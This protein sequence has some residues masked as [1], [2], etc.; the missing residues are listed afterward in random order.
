MPSQRMLLTPLR[1]SL[2][3]A[4]QLPVSMDSLPRLPFPPSP[5]TAWAVEDTSIQ[6]AWGALPTGT[7]TAAAVGGGATVTNVIDHPGGPGAVDIDGL[8]PN[9]Q[10]QLT[11]EVAGTR[12]TCSARTLTPPPGAELFRFATISDMHLGSD[13]FGASKRM[14]DRSNHPE[15]FALRSASH[16]IN[17]ATAWGAKHL[18]IKGDAAH[19]ARVEDFALL[20]E[21]V[22]RHVDVPMSLLPGNHDNDLRA[23][24]LPATVGKRALRYERGVSHLDVP[25]LR[26]V[27]GDTTI[28]GVGSGTLNAIGDALLTAAAESPS[29]TAFLA[30]HQQLQVNDPNRYWPPGIPSDQSDPFLEQLNHAR[31]GAVVTSGHTHRN[32]SRRHKSVLVTEVA[33]THHW[34][35]VWAGYV[36]HEGGIRQVVRRIVDADIVEWHEYSKNAVGSIWGRY[37]PGPINQRCLVHQWPS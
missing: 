26:I 25:G 13:H 2:Q 9:T 23:M 3:L 1:L 33:A 15:P 32:R 7:L 27:V 6:L 19:H 24:P 10:Y 31:P 17:A 8:D 16:A 35:G 37:A 12:E 36:V 21:L 28:T 18:V 22:D 14:R 34:P 5:L 29:T 4:S 20:G 11:V 30:V